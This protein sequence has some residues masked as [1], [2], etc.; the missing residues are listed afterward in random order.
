MINKKVK[1][2]E[3][4]RQGRRP[5]RPKSDKNSKVLLSLGTDVR[6]E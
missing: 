3:L 1:S 2:G 4:P 5:S 6:T